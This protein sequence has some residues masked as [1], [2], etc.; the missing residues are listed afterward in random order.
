MIGVV[1]QILAASA[2]HGGVLLGCAVF[3]GVLIPPLADLLHPFVTPSV[4]GMM[5][6]VLLRVDIQ[7]ALAHL[8]PRLAVII[9]AHALAAPL[10]A[11]TIIAPLGLEPGIAAGIIIAAT[12]CAATTGPAFARLLGLDAELALLVV[13]ATT[14][15]LPL[16][17]PPMIFALIG[18]DLALSLPAFA[19]R[20]AL[21][22]GLPFLLALAIRRWAGPARLTPLGPAIDGA[23]VW[24]V[25]LFGFGVMKGL[26]TRLL[27]DPAWVL[28]A[29]LAAFAVNFG[30]NLATTLA[31][32]APLGWRLAA[33]AG[34][35]GGNRNM[36]LY[37]AILP[38]AADPRL[39]LF[40]APCQFPLFLSPFLLRA[41]I[42][43]Q[44]QG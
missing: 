8:R 32:A 37:L 18:L 17:A 20:L 23:V 9:A 34:L 2:R 28:K 30:L 15:L 16:T 19:S 3:G 12:G 24:L 10:L 22:V 25:M 43:W 35:L 42:R 6:L 31:L 39:A 29:T 36:A 33:T 14:L 27:D 13:L 44:R 21:I 26:T 1:L 38:A 5:T 11:W 41:F 4:I 7:A 40:F